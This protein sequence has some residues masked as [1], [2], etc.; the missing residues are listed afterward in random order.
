[1][2]A[3]SSSTVSQSYKND[4]RLLVL[5]LLVPLSFRYLQDV[6]YLKCCLRFYRLQ[7]PF[8]TPEQ[9]EKCIKYGLSPF[10]HYGTLVHHHYY[11]SSCQY[12]IW[13]L[14]NLRLRFD[15]VVGGVDTMRGLIMPCPTAPLSCKNKTKAFLVLNLSTL[16]SILIEIPPF[17]LFS[18]S[19]WVKLFFTSLKVPHSV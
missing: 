2:L 15:Q 10:T 9:C 16:L 13:D 14:L 4:C 7:T 8:S 18:F 6:S 11:H 5:L 19:I 1:M 12:G 17:V 3:F